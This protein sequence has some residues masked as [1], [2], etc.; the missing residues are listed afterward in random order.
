MS[1][2]AWNEDAVEPYAQA[3]TQSEREA[4]QLARELGV[5]MIAV[6]RGTIIGPG[7]Q[8]HTPST[9]SF[10]LL[11]RGK[12]PFALPITMEFVDVRDVADAHIQVYENEKASGRYIISHRSMPLKEVFDHVKAVEPEVKVPEKER[13]GPLVGMVPFLDWLGNKLDGTPRFASSAL[14]KEYANREQKVSTQR[15]RRELGWE[16]MPITTSIK[17]TVSWVRENFI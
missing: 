9:L 3:K 12:V 1:E 8:R 16:P 14:I 10:E 17:D 5:N 13:P 15:A 11:L 6:L 2:D 4:W 7:F